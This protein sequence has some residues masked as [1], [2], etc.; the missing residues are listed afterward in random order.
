MNRY[1]VG[2]LEDHPATA[3]GIKAQLSA[4]PDLEVVWLEHYFDSLETW[5]Q[6]GAPDL[7]ILDISVP[8]NPEDP[9]LYPIFDELPSLLSRFPHLKILVFSMH[10]RPALLKAINATGVHGYI[11]KEDRGSFQRLDQ[12]VIDIL[13]TGRR[14]FSPQVQAV[15]ADPAEI[16]TLTWRQNEILTMILQDPDLTNKELADLLVV[17]P[18][19]IRNHLSI[20]YTKLGVSSRASAI[21]KAQELG[22]VRPRPEEP[23]ELPRDLP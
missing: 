3:A 5:L 13:T 2:I 6:A 1:R 10:N 4:N 23:P 16:P 7:L 14:Y 19:T 12:I 15:L 20:I 22:L 18:S 17:A 21:M 11:L 9:E 8:K